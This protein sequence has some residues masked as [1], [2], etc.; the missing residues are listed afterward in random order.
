MKRSN[1]LQYYIYISDTKLQM[2]YDQIGEA[3]CHKIAKELKIDLK[4]LSVSKNIESVNKT[5]QL[6]R[7]K[8]VTEHIRKNCEVG[9]IEDGMPYVE[10]TLD[11]RWGPIQGYWKEEVPLV[12]FGGISTN[13]IV[14]LSGSKKHLIGGNPSSCVESGSATPSIIRALSSLLEESVS[15][16]FSSPSRNIPQDRSLFLVQIA[17]GFMIGPTQRLTFLAKT[18]LAGAKPEP[19]Y[20]APWG[21][22]VK[23]A[24]LG[25][26]LWVAMA[27]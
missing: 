3:E 19:D 24:W 8:L 18:L 13:T 14:G 15:D 12:Y 26:P 16:A 2:F 5:T 17:T 20:H 7:V 21:R 27:D 10:D 23:N 4:L 9:K 11:M 22:E 1:S 6:S 25:T